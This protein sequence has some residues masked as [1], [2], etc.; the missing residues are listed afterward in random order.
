MIKNRRRNKIEKILYN[1]RFISLVGFLVIIMISVPLA[2]QVSK[3]YYIDEEIKELEEEIEKIESKNGNLKE[4]ISYLESDSFVEEQA[5]LN[6]GLKKE[7]EKVVIIKES[8]LESSINS[9]KVEKENLNL[10]IIKWWKYFF[11]K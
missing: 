10:N 1:K 7:G 3:R 2:K 9:S 5:R 4:F 8:D 11:V 6:L